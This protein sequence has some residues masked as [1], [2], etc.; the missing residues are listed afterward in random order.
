MQYAERAIACINEAKA[1]IQDSTKR[2]V[3]GAA[4]SLCVYR[5]PGL[6]QQYRAACP[7]VQVSIKVLDC[8][9]YLTSLEH[10]TVDILFSLGNRL[11]ATN[12]RIVQTR[13]DPV[14]ICACPSHPLRRKRRLEATD[15]AKWPVLLT[16][17]GCCYRNAFLRH[18]ESA[19]VYPTVVMETNSIQALK[20]AA[21]QGIGICVLPKM[22]VM[23]ELEH[24]TLVALPLPGVNW[25]ITSQVTYHKDKWISPA[26]SALLELL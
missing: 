4:E 14:S 18:L 2:L 3:I 15:F 7:D 6:L 13:K 17:T 9:E 1:A 21:I 12:C 23:E 20:Q 26:L 10:N 11:D 25:N 16:G 19:Y 24:N 8:D 5:L 22:A